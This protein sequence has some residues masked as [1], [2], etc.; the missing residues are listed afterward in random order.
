[1]SVG[2][3]NGVM[4]GKNY[5]R[6]INCHKVMAESLERLL[7]DRYLKTR[8]LKGLP[9]DLLQAIDHIINERS[10]EN[11]DAAMQNKALANF[12]EKYSLFRQQVRKTV[13]VWLT[14]MNHVSLVFS[15]QYTVKI[16]DYYLYGTCLS[17]MVIYFSALVVKI[18]P[19]IS[20]TSRCSWSTLKKL[21]RA[22]PSYSN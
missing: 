9:G 20:A 19:D 10:S 21:T 5:S 13:Q 8:S 15:L 7:L 2:F 1:M 18:M 22:P 6:A 16:N 3:M 17:K 4:F 12:L 14:Y 11:L